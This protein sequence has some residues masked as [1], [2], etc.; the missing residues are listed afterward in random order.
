ME[1]S[2]TQLKYIIEY[3]R[4]S[5]DWVRSFAPEFSV[6]FDT[7]KE[8]ESLVA[9][10]N[11]INNNTYRVKA[12]EMMYTEDCNVPSYLELRG[13]LEV[14][15]RARIHL[16]EQRPTYEFGGY[17]LYKADTILYTAYCALL[18]EI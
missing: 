6:E 2:A 1:N 13:A 18:F 7:R 9:L 15:R 5:G 3:H 11:K 8:A 10:E 14:L 16:Q 12:V 4:S 17:S